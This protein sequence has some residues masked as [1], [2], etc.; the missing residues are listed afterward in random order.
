MNENVYETHDVEVAEQLLTDVYTRIQLT[1]TDPN[2]SLRITTST[3]DPQAWF[4]RATFGMRLN[5]QG[6]PLGAIPI[7]HVCAGTASW[8]TG[9]PGQVAGPGDVFVLL[10]PD[11]E[12]HNSIDGLDLDL[13]HLDPALLAQVA[14]G[15]PRTSPA[16]RFTDHRPVPAAAA[17]RW[18]DT[19]DYVKTAVADLPADP[20][21][22]LTG[23]LTRILA[24]AALT[25]FPNNMLTD[26]TIEDRRD[27]HPAT[28]RRAISF[29]DDN[30][31]CD[32]SAADIAAAAHVTIRTL[33]LAFRRHLD[34]NPMAYLRRAR[35]ARAHHDL[36]TADPATTT[37]GEIAVRWGFPDHS[38]FA[39]SYRAAYGQPPSRTLR[40]H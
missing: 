28:L 12:W 11:C 27:A 4:S 39:Q 6:L 19:Y 22:L 8:S 31:Q 37:V 26:P 29:I 25:V 2:P 13:A 7:G 21:P 5:A 40:H 36:K 9:Q 15:P 20:A 3:L 34:T 10:P 23:S 14:D 18:T 32:I 24:A 33:Q 16:L 1:V 38:R 35:L 17:R 30:P